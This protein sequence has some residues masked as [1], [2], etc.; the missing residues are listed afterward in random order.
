M[1]SIKKIF[2]VITIFF[3]ALLFTACNN[4][5]E[6]DLKRG[7]KVLTYLVSSQTA[8]AER[9]LNEVIADFNEI[10]AEEGYFI[11]T[12][13]PG[14]D[15]YTALGNKFAARQA[16]DIFLMETGYF[17]AYARTGYLEPLDEYLEKSSVLSRD[18]LWEVNSY[19]RYDKNLG[20]GKGQ[21][22]A[23]IKDYSP[24]FMLI[25]NKTMLDS[26]NKNHPEDKIII[27][28]TEP[29]TWQEFY[30]IASKI[31]AAQKINY[32]TSIG[33]EAVKHLH[34]WVQMT[35]SSLFKEDGKTLNVDDENVRAAFAF[36]T[37]LQKDNAE[38]F[39]E[40]L[41]LNHNN[42][43][44]PASYTKGASTSEVEVFKQQKAFSIFNGLYSFYT[45]GLY[46]T[47]FEIG[48]A[49]PPVKA[50][51]TTPYAT[52]S[53]MVANCISAT[54]KYKDVAF[55]FLEYYMTVG[56]EKFAEV[57]F[58]IPGNKT[59]AGTD[60]FLNPQ[61]EKVK[62]MNNYFYNFVDAGYVHPTIYNPNISF[63][64]LETHFV[65]QLDKYYDGGQSFNEMLTQLQKYLA[66]EIG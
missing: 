49:P 28:E 58:N 52:T 12:E 30:E 7:K 2:L 65:T 29:L 55:R 44:A 48:I 62:A 56:M 43:I 50:G 15:Y 63:K 60:V 11:E 32:G 36:F 25:Y 6:R 19:Y 59:I 13:T 61:N 17:N 20:A 40:Y 64:K 10:I 5:G 31:Q 26:Y 54:S 14:G 16:P 41:A 18:D 1:K 4:D 53:A 37:A 34:E 39:P 21:L 35:G 23:L 42:G 47:D 24:D 8:A 45:F 57:G 46:N 22:Y 3:S 38:E 66:A 27:S 33:F 9:V 51:I